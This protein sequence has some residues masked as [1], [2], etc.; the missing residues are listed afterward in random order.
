MNIIE[1]VKN[2]L[3]S[4]KKE[5][6]V[7]AT[8]QQSMSSVLTTYV[9]PLSLIGAAATLIGWGLIGKSYGGFGYTF[10]VK[11]WDIGIKYAIISLVSTIVGFL[12]TTFVVDVLAPSFG[13]EKNLDRSAQFVAYSYTPSLI[14]GILNI[15]PSLALLVMV[16]GLYSIYLMYLGLGPVKKTPDD[17]RV[18]YLVISIVVLMVAY[19]VLGLILVSILGLGGLGAGNH[20]TIG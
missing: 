13:S 3:V 10:T 4:P 19:F 20:V 2:I 12:I 14:A 16:A 9:V 8:E 17:K 11:G 15:L 18:V 7:I 1:R 5:W 6:G